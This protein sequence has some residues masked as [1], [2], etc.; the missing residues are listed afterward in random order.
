M[1]TNPGLLAMIEFGFEEMFGFSYHLSEALQRYGP[2][3]EPTETGFN[4]ST[5]SS[6]T[7]YAYIDEE[8]NVGRPS[9]FTSML[10]E[11]A[12]YEFSAADAI[13]RGLDWEG[14][15]GVVV[16]DVFPFFSFLLFFSFCF[17]PLRS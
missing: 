1:L 5:G 2:S 16:V 4:I 15:G 9:A 13:V 8:R 17:L 11:T 7:L 10:E 14:M 12:S 3:E 6:S